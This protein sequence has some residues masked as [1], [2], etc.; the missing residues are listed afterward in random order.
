MFGDIF[1]KFL[2]VITC[3]NFCDDSN[4][5]MLLKHTRV[6]IVYCLCDHV[7]ITNLCG[8]KSLR[9][10]YLISK[11]LSGDMEIIYGLYLDLDLC[12]FYCRW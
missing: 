9:K 11:T 4:M 10:L 7:D 2:I 8:I 3:V 12:V 6:K 5:V 1:D